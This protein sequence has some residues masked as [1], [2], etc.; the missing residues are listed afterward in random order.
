MILNL[1]AVISLVGAVSSFTLAVIFPPV[2]E[3]IK[4]GTKDLKSSAGFSG[5]IF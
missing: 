5:K 4:S 2:I 1:G 3:I